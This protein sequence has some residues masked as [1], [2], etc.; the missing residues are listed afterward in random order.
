MLDLYESLTDPKRAGTKLFTP[1]DQF[2]K[3][4]I[5]VMGRADFVGRSGRSEGDI[6]RQLKRLHGRF[7][8][9]D[10]NFDSPTSFLYKGLTPKIL[11]RINVGKGE[12]E[13]PGTTAPTEGPAEVADGS[14][15]N[16]QNVL[17]SK[18]QDRDGD[19]LD[20][21]GANV[22]PKAP[23][24][25]QHMPWEPCG[26]MVKV[27]AKTEE[28]VATECAIA[29]TALGR[30]S[31]VLVEFGALRISHGFVPVDYDE[32]VDENGNRLPG[33]NIRTYNVLEVS[34]VSIPSNPDAVITAFSRNKLFHPLTKGWGE[35]LHRKRTV[36][37]NG[38][39][40]STVE[41]KNE[42]ITVNVN[43]TLPAAPEVKAAEVPAAT[44]ATTPA[45]AP[46]PAATP[47]AVPAA[48]PAKAAPKAAKPAG[49]KADGD[50]EAAAGGEGSEGD[51]GDAGKDGEGDA[52]G[53]GETTADDEGET[54]KSG[55]GV[56]NEIAGLLKG[57]SDG[58]E[59]PQEAKDRL[60][61]AGNM[62]ANA[63]AAIEEA[64][65]KF[66]EA[67]DA[68]DIKEMLLCA[69]SATDSVLAGIKGAVEELERVVNIDG[70]DENQQAGLDDILDRVSALWTD[71]SAAAGM[72]PEGYDE[73]GEGGEGEGDEE[74]ETAAAES[75][76]DDNE[77]EPTDSMPASFDSAFAKLSE[78]AIVDGLEQDQKD[79]IKDLASAL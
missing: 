57:M 63:D 19:V 51:A 26:K 59:M 50:D 67:A 37:G 10:P 44:P 18:N 65:T 45:A 33:W 62:L 6:A 71:V 21:M 66:K 76:P 25:W 73:A 52:E 3:E 75:D 2:L 17:T 7:I 24:L 31:A 69:Q 47:A 78:L 34:L 41:T 49:K 39:T 9:D 23:L 30:D 11:K 38:A 1:A 29:D 13:A 72:A 74:T 5:D 14:V 12:G 54:A 36:Q 40:L 27:I 55:Q 32:R 35:A 42:G 53:S 20:P 79:A 56:I 8:Y 60:A 77:Y 4:M 58:T 16:F 70:L 64:G 22:D 61:T 28:I 46:I 68:R 43:V 15:M 48:V